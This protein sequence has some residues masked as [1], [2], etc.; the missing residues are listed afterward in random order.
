MGDTKREADSTEVNDLRSE[1]KQ[2]KAVVAELTL[3][4]RR[5]KKKLAGP[6]NYN[7]GRLIRRDETEKSEII[8]IVEH[9]VLPVK[10]TLDELEVPRSTF[11]CWYKKYQEDGP[12]GL[13]DRR[14]NP[15]PIWLTRCFEN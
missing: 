4:N 5:L 15:R 6:G 14:P 2:F 12:D 8:H 7:V 10:K 1:N 3:N 13:I 9:S 11:Y